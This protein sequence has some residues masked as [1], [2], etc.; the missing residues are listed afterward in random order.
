MRFMRTFFVLVALLSFPAL[1]MAASAGEHEARMESYAAVLADFIKDGTLPDGEKVEFMEDAG[2]D[3]F[4]VVDVTGDDA[5]ELIIRHTAAS[6]ADQLELVLTYDPEGDALV[7]IFRSFPSVT[8]YGNGVLRADISHNQGLAGDGDFW[9]HTLCRYNPSTKQY[10][11]CGFVDAWNKAEF[12]TN[13][14]E[15]DKPFP[16]DIDGDGDGMIYSV[17]LGEKRL[18]DPDA[19]YVDGPAYRAW[20]DEILGGAEAIELPWVPANEDGLKKLK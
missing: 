2:E 18:V 12:P 16:D 14:F 3:V 13:P 10:D 15:G 4:A 20:A 8:Y 1:C 17:T 7:T 9:P 5:P 11:D 19:E 6:M